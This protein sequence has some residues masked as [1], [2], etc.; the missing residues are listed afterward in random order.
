MKI[1]N[2]KSEEPVIVPATSSKIF[3]KSSLNIFTQLYSL[4][5]EGCQ[6]PSVAGQFLHL[7]AQNLA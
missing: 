2:N 6:M 7:G 3:N 1:R 5:Q 4:C